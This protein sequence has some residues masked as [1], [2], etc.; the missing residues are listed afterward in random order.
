MLL[1]ITCNLLQVQSLGCQ[2]Q[3]STFAK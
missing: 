1:V 2:S 3:V